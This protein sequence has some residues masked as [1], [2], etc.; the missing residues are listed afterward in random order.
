MAAIGRLFLIDTEEKREDA[1]VSRVVAK[2][3]RSRFDDMIYGQPPS[4]LLI[5]RMILENCQE[6]VTRNEELTQTEYG[7]YQRRKK[8]R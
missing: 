5:L 4:S 8:V 3:P 1:D 7:H 6:A 2:M